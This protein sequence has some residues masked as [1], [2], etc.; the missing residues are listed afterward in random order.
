MERISRF[1]VR[2]LSVLF[3]LVM[4]FFAFRLYDLQ[5]IRTGGVIDNTT[6]FTTLTRVKAARGDILDRNGNLLVSNRASYDLVINHYV[7]ITADGTNDYLYK[8]VKRCEEKGI[9]YSD[10]FPVSRERPFVYTTET[11][12]STYQKYYQKYLAYMDRLDSDI[13]A[14]LLIAHLREHYDLPTEWTDEEARAV[15]GLWYEMDLRRCEGTLSN[16]VFLSD[17][18]DAALASIAEL[19]IPGMNVEASTVREYNTK[20]AAH[21]LGYIGPMTAEQWESYKEDEDY[22]MD[23]EIGQDGIEAAFE[24]Y[25]HGVDGW[26]EDTVT[27]SGKLV[28]STFITEPRAGSNVELTIDINLQREAEEQLAITMDALRTAVKE[29]GSP[30]DGADA[31]GAAVVALD[32]RDNSVLV[33]ASYPAYDLTTFFENYNMILEQ[34]YDPLYNRALLGTYPPGSTYKMSMVVSAINSGVINS[35]TLINDTGIFDK[36]KN[37]GFAPKCLRYSSYG[38]SHGNLN[39]AQALQVSCNY[40]F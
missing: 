2:I 33:C 24:K 16:Y 14:P 12:N 4:A 6:T 8:L 39:A 17:V 26:R 32:A 40:F 5:V 7:L 18:D 22:S 21:I 20:Y 38:L 13:T 28:S 9:E 25:L 34:P 10:H 29:D 36:Y 31:E 15:L 23:S 37:A 30:G 1:R 35:S 3:A 19:N 11:L 27:T